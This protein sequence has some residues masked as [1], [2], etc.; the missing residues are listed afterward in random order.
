MCRHKNAAISLESY[1]DNWSKVPVLMRQGV[2]A[3][4]VV[5]GGTS[6]YA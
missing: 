1:L 2:K 5:P 3:S 6:A 4:M